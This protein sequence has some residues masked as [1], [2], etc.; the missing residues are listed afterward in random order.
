MF[1]AQG[2]DYTFPNLQS[3]LIEA[4]LVWADEDDK[5]LM[6]IAAERITQLY[7]WKAEGIHPAAAMRAI[8]VFDAE[9]SAALRAKGYNSTDIFIP[10]TLFKSFSRRLMRSFGWVKA[11]PGLTKRF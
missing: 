1:E 7:L 2:F 5:P 10:P 8:A 11:W 3:P 9:M 4:V 6:A